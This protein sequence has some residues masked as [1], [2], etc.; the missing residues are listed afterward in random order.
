MKKSARTLVATVLALLVCLSPASALA[1]EPDNL[2]PFLFIVDEDY[3]EISLYTSTLENDYWI[4]LKDYSVTTKSGDTYVGLFPK[5][6][7]MPNETANKGIS[8][9]PPR[10]E[11]SYPN[12]G[13]V[14]SA[15]AYWPSGSGEAYRYSI[16]A[17]YDVPK[18]KL[19]TRDHPTNV[20]SN[21][22]ISDA[23]NLLKF[24]ADDLLTKEEFT[25][26][27]NH[28]LV[29]GDLAAKDSKDSTAIDS[30][31]PGATFSLDFS[32]NASWLPRYLTGAIFSPRRVGGSY[33]SE[34]SVK[35]GG[36]ANTPLPD[37]TTYYDESTVTR[38][39][40]LAFTLDIPE[41]IEVSDSAAATL[42][43]ISGF[44]TPTVQKSDDGK[45]LIVKVSFANPGKKD[46]KDWVDILRS[47][48]L[49]VSKIKLNI[50]GLSVA[51]D[52]T[53]GSQL[54][55]RGTAAGYYDLY[56][57]IPDSI[58]GLSSSRYY[59]FFGAQQD[60]AGLDKGADENK[61]KQ[62]SYTLKVV[63]PAV[64]KTYDVTYA[65]VSATDDQKLPEDVLKL[66]PNAL[67]GQKDGSTITIEP[68]TFN[69]VKVKGGTWHFEG[70]DHESVK[71]NGASV[72]V[73]GKWSFKADPVQPTSDEPTSSG[74][75]PT[76]STGYIPYPFPPTDIPSPT[77][78]IPCPPT[79]PTTT[80][81]TKPNPK[82]ADNGISAIAVMALLGSAALLVDL[83][84]KWKEN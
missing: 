5:Y 27:L 39:T 6:L 58:E 34:D 54:L 56:L 16:I 67:R 26:P 81:H 78:E 24:T 40:G 1:A 75:E 19:D 15:E 84:K 47:K 33:P 11:N 63:K 21:E 77:D 35:A 13:I 18:D 45:T 72:P 38:D 55:I 36:D 2:M 74:D 42:S 62:I 64:A 53:D 29:Y 30:Y 22:P 46:L 80:H 76:S 48:D 10:N 68:K 7:P 32:L 79:E 82:T 9:Q 31:A 51:Q 14:N 49:D 65:F 70:W 4:D 50:S 43:G 59:M 69:D 12:A 3:N 66:L 8:F 17:G 61:P 57:G 44:G 52:A 23:V 28:L 37:V 73:T 41:G 25:D 83:R 71:L 60:P 20:W